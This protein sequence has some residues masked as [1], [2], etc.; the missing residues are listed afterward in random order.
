MSSGDWTTVRHDGYGRWSLMRRSEAFTTY[1]T[2]VQDNPDPR[3]G[4]DWCG[5][6]RP[7]RP[8]SL[9]R[10]LWRYG[11]QSDGYGARVNELSGR[12]CSVACCRT[13]HD[14]AED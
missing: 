13:Y 4:C 12:F 6:W 10:Y 5:S 2:T 11:T 7:Q 8:G 9:T 14:L 1:N 3:A